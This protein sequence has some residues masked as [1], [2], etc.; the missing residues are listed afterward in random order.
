MLVMDLSPD[1]KQR[2]LDLQWNVLCVTCIFASQLLYVEI[3]SMY[4]MDLVRVTDTRIFP[5]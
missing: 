4:Y 2:T 5:S 3:K 1:W